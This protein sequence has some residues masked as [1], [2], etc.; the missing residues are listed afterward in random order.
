[1]KVSYRKLLFDISHL[2]IAN[3][4]AGIKK[5]IGVDGNVFKPLKPAT[6]K[7]KIRHGSATPTMRMRDTG[8][9]LENGYGF[10]IQ[11]ADT[12]A[13][14]F[15]QGTEH[16]SGKATYREIAGYNQDSRSWHFGVSED[17]S[18][19]IDTSISHYIDKVVD[20]TLKPLDAK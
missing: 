9:Y 6:I 14:I 18:R 7:A 12:V 3:M 13:V 2:I 1:M 15:P 10:S 8:D 17:T 19:K 5:Q 20:D 16:Q 4:Q 11:Q